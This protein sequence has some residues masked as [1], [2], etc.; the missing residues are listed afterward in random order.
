MYRRVFYSFNYAED[1]W[2]ASQVRNMGVVEGNR[3]A[4]DNEWQ[5]VSK[6]G[7]S[8]ITRWI[9]Q[10]M[11]GRSALIVLIGANTAGRRW[12]NY[13]I[14]H[15]WNKRMGVLGVYISGLRDKDGRVSIYGRNPFDDFNLRGN[16]L[17]S[18]VPTFMPIGYSSQEIYAS[19]RVNLSVY[20]ERAIS[21]RSAYA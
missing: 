21:V 1:A 16:V 9:N 18:I 4:T 15:A 20:I 19:I 7:D 13:E 12:I 5:D 3:P 6:G 11:Q 2:R 17:T 14:E 10:Q 8:A